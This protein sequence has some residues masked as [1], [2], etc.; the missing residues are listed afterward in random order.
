MLKQRVKLGNVSHYG[1][2]LLELSV[3]EREA[4]LAIL[5]KLIRGRGLFGELSPMSK[6]SHLFI[7]PENVCMRFEDITLEDDGFYGII[8]PAGPMGVRL[9]QLSLDSYYFRPRLYGFVKG[10]TRLSRRIVTW[11]VVHNY[12]KPP[13]AH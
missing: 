4:M 9:L 3:E 12:D 10:A 7:R 8:E 5:Q 6:P 2:D 11:D 1:D 13:S